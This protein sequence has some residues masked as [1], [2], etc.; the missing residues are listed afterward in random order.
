MDPQATPTFEEWAEYCLTLGYADF[1]GRSG[2]PEEV[3]DARISRFLSLPPWRV[4]EYITR[5]FENSREL[6]TRYTPDQ[7]GDATWFIFG[8]ASGYF[9]E[10]RSPANAKDVQLR[11][12]RSVTTLYLDL[13]DRLCNFGGH[14]WK[15][16][17]DAQRLDGAVYMIWDMNGIEGAVLFPE[18]APHLG[19]AGFEILETVLTQCRTG[20]C[21]KSALHALGHVNTFHPERAEKMV[22]AFLERRRPELPEW[23][24]QYAERARVGSVQ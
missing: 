16:C 2:D 17:S 8:I 1:H 19:E 13:Y 9:H 3:A 21:L 6:A 12:F 23:L 11:C 20:S 14:D 18:D 7:I 24:T 15:D 10:V 22:M 4:T 5:L